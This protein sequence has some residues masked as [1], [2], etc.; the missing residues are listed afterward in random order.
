MIDSLIHAAHA[1]PA[2]L[3]EANA[4]KAAVPATDLGWAGLILLFP[5]VS[6][7]L[8]GACAAMGVKG[9]LP[10]AITALALLASFGTTL[11]LYLNF[12]A[13]GPRTVHLFDWVAVAWTGKAATWSSFMAPFALYIDS[14]TLL[15]ML[16]VT[17]LG[18]LIAIYATE[19]MESDVGKG[20]ARF[21]GSVSVFLFAMGALVMG[22]NLI[23]LY[24]GWE[25]VG[26]ASYLLIGY[27]YQRPSAVAA[28]KKAFIMN[29]IGDLGLALAVFLI[30]VNYGTVEYSALFSAIGSGTDVA[31]GSEWSKAAIPF[32]LML[33]A[34]GKSAQFPLYVWLPDAMEG[35]TPVSALIHAATMVTAGIY[36][37]ART[38]PLFDLHPWALPTV[39]IVGCGTALLAATIG[40]AQYDI[41]RVMAYSTV[42]QLGYMFLGLGLGTTFGAVYHVFTHAFFKALLFLCCGAIMH[43]MAG[44]LDLRKMSGMRNVKGFGIVSWTFL[45]GCLCLAGFPFSAGFFSKDTIIAQ[46]FVA[47]R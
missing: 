42:S 22:G 35:P 33:G 29:R 26:L 38:F 44:Q 30:W 36:L 8:C 47:E 46:A 43:G 7:I 2:V 13:D 19:Y 41:K 28:A 32:C 27:Y 39:A 24:L 14:L 21:F 18:S 37:I 3:G 25:G 17:G 20:Y 16:F 34:F 45:I 11:A 6:A 4:L 1:M 12:P 10:G 40:M 9:K 31:T 15:W 23:L 5:A